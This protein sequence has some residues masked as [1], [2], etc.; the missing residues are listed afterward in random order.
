MRAY[1]GKF[2]R[3][4]RTKST[5]VR[6]TDGGLGVRA[7]AWSVYTVNC[8]NTMRLS[9]MPTLR[10]A[11][12]DQHD[13]ANRRCDWWHQHHDAFRTW[14]RPWQLSLNMA[15]AGHSCCCVGSTCQRLEKSQLT[16]N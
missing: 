8:S 2:A 6:L 9:N 3:E 12:Y 15:Q 4:L 14:P 16:L 1:W 5:M 13:A 10:P 11:Q 7:P